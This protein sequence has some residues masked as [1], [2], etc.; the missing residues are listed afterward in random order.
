MEHEFISKIEFRFYYRIMSIE[1][2][3]M[4]DLLMFFCR[5]IDRDESIVREKLK[6]KRSNYAK[7]IYEMRVHHLKARGA[8]DEATH[9][10]RRKRSVQR[11]RE[12]VC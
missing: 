12:R 2:L 1:K 4:F 10:R 11:G 8:S 6:R 5:E 7:R 3:R 9:E